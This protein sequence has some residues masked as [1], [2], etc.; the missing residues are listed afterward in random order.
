MIDAAVPDLVVALTPTSGISEILLDL[1]DGARLHHGSRGDTISVVPPMVEERF[2]LSDPHEVTSLALSDAV[3]SD[4]LEQHGLTT[5]DYLHFAGEIVPDAA[6]VRTMKTLW[7]ASKATGDANSLYVDG[8]T[9]QL[10]SQLC[11]SNAL[12]PILDVERA[13]ARIARVLDYVEA[14]LTDPLS[15][16]ALAAI[17]AMSAG[18]FSRCFKATTGEP[19]WT[20]VQRRRCERAKDL[21]VHSREPLAEIAYCCGFANQAHMTTSLKER[22]GATP[23]VIRA[24]GES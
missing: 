9:L 5:S 1:G 22:L 12:S 18:H 7:C 13:D 11:A 21:L 17:A 16:S 10:L 15:V 8:L 14:H 24:E 23:G 2:C 6:A 20:Y 19:V 4:L 3:V